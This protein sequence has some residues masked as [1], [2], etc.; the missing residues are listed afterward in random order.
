MG[1]QTGLRPA[2][3]LRVRAL[4]SPTLLGDANARWAC[5]LGGKPLAQWLGGLRWASD[6]WGGFKDQALANG[7]PAGTALLYVQRH[8]QLKRRLHVFTLRSERAMVAVAAFR[9]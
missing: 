2:L 3:R 8:L 1:A 5:G 7:L 4:E 9:T 6:S